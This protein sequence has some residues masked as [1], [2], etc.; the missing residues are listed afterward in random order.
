PKTNYTWS[1]YKYGNGYSSTITKYCV[2]SS[3]G[4]VD[5][6]TTL[7]LA[8]DAAHVNWGGAWRMPT[9]AEHDELRK[10]SLCTWT[11]TAQN[12]VNGYKVTSKKNGNSIFLPAAGYLNYS[13]LYDAGDYG[14]YW[15]C[16]LNTDSNNGAYDLFFNSFRVEINGYSDRYY[17]LPVR[18]VCP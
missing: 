9:K 18:A 15:L 5:N 7:E 4:T 16:S 10:S 6:K 14:C 11:W 1:T 2:N 12:G 3:Y 8:D 13:N 17:G